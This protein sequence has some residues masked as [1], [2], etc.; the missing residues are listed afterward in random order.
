MKLDKYMY[1]I[2]PMRVEMLT[3]GPTDREA[4]IL[5]DHVAYLQ[6]LAGESVVLLA[7]RTQT[8]DDSSFGIVILQAASQPEAHDIM[9]ADPA[10]KHAV[11]ETELFPYKIAV[12]SRAITAELE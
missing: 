7:G 9:M 1:K 11:M 2:R 6:Q 8:A 10:I 3:E 4:S 5:Q 12:L